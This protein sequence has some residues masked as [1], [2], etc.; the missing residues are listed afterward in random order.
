MYKRR[1]RSITL[2][3]AALLATTALAEDWTRF[4][5]ANGLG[6]SSSKGLPAELGRETNKIWE[7]EVPFGRSSPV[8]AGDRIFL[9]AIEG[10]ALVTLAIDRASGKTLW[11]KS[12]QPSRR[13]EY[14]HDTDS[15]TTTPVTD[16]RNVYVFFQEFGIVSYDAQGEQRWTHPLGPFRNFYSI[17][18]SPIVS[19]DLLYMFCDQAEGSFVV[20]LDT[21]TGEQAWRRSRPGRLESYT[22]PILYPDEKKPAALVIYGSAWIDAYELRTGETLWSVGEVGVGPVSSPVVAGDTIFVAAPSHGEHGWPPFAGITG[23]FDKDGDGKLARD[24]VAEAWLIQHYGWLDRDGDGVISE[25]DWTELGKEVMTE[26]WGAYAIRLGGEKAEHLWNYRSNVSEIASPLV[27]D[28]VF[29]M[30][31]KGILTSLDV[32]TGELIKRDRIA[33]GSPKVYASPVAADG[34][35]YLATLDGSVVVIRAAGEWETLSRVDLDDEIWATPAIA[36]GR[37]YLRTRHKLFSFG[38]S[39]GGAS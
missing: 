20:A 9:T 28:G 6:T 29:Y 4:R 33:E 27:L 22:T 2:T 12:V 39:G 35:I 7:I 25:S 14:H 8:V 19:G 32:K 38:S 34:K 18:A 11:K 13:D 5:G 30:V 15:A 24:E 36:D 37:L 3:L 26:H 1:S 21:K 23:E 16:G 10:E 31:D 17:A